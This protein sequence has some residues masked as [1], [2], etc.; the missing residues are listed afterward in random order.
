MISRR[1]SSR[2]GSLVVSSL[3]VTTLCGLFLCPR[4]GAEERKFVVMLAVPPAKSIEGGLSSLQLPSRNAIWDQYFDVL[5][6]QGPNRVDSF[7]EYW[8][9]ISYGAVSV[10][11][12][13][14]DWVEVPWPILPLLPDPNNPGER[15]P[16]VPE[17][18]TSLNGFNLPF[19]DLNGT[20]DLEQF[21]GEAF[22]QSEQ[23]FY[24]DYNGGLPGTG[25]EAFPES[26]ITQRPQGFVDFNAITGEP[27]WTPGERF[28]DLN[29]NGM[30]DAL[31]EG[32][33]DGWGSEYPSECCTPAGGSG[34]AGQSGSNGEVACEELVCAA[35]PG[36]C[37]DDPGWDE[38]CAAK[39]KELCV[40]GDAYQFPDLC[41]CEQD[42]EIDTGEFC[43]VD[44]D[45][46]WD[47]PE[48]FEDYLVIYNPDSQLAEGRWIK[49]DP[50]YKNR[51]PQSRAWAEAYIR[52]NYPGYA[53]EPLRTKDDSN[54]HGFM[55][56]FGNDKYDGPDYWYDSGSQEAPNPGSKLQQQPSP[57][58][59][60]HA[61]RTPIPDDGVNGYGLFS[62]SFEEWWEDYWHDKHLR[63]GYAEADIPQ[64]PRPPDWDLSGQKGRTSP[65]PNLQPFNPA[66]PSVGSLTP[67][68]EDLRSFNPNTGGSNARVFCIPPTDPV[69]GCDD[70][71]MEPDSTGNGSGLGTTDG[72]VYPDMW[73][74]N[75]DR[76]P[77]YYDGPA[78]FDDLPSSMYHARSVS[79][80]AWDPISG[81]WG[82]GG[83]GR[84]G[85]VTSANNWASY[86]DDRGN[87]NPESAGNADGKIPA[88]GPGAYGVHGSGGCDGGNVLNL[89]F[90]TWDHARPKPPW[91]PGGTS[92]SPAVG[93]AYYGSI[94]GEPG[95]PDLDILYTV[96]TDNNRLAWINVEVGQQG[97]PT[98]IAGSGYV[99]TDTDLSAVFRRVTAI[100][101]APPLV[102][103]DLTLYAV[104][105]NAQNT[106]V[107]G[108][109]SLDTGEATLIANIGG[110]RSISDMA[111]GRI[112][113]LVSGL[114][115]EVE[116]ASMYTLVWEDNRSKLYR[117]DLNN[118]AMVFRK[119][120]GQIGSGCQGLAY[121]EPVGTI[122]PGTFYTVDLAHKQLAR[123]DWDVN[124]EDPNA[125]ERLNLPAVPAD[126]EQKIEFSLQGLSC[127]SSVPL[128]EVPAVLFAVDSTDHVIKIDTADIEGDPEDPLSV[129]L[130]AGEADVLGILGLAAFKTRVMKRDFNLDGLIDMGEVRAEGTENYAIDHTGFTP[131]DGGPHVLYPFNRRR[132]TEDVVAA[133]DFSTDWDL[134]V[135]RVGDGSSAVN[136]LHSVVMFPPGVIADG[137][138]AGGR[139]LFH[140]PA[141]GMDLPVQVLEEPGNP[142]SPIMFSDFASP[143][144][145]TS[146]TG[147][148]IEDGSFGKGLMCHEW[149]HVW[150]GYPD[151]YD[152]DEYGGGVI[153]KPV[154]AWDIMSGGMVHPCPV[155]KEGFRGNFL[156]KDWLGT[157][158][159][160]WIDVTS[161]A[162]VLEPLEETSITL[163]DYA[164]DPSTAAFYYENP[165]NSGERFYFYRLT[166]QTPADP[167]AV[168]FS[169]NAPGE[170]V[171][172]MHTDFG[173]N[174]ESVPIQQRRG[175]HFS[176]Q[177]VQADGLHQLENGVN[178]GD[179]GDPFP[180]SED[181]TEWNAN[182]DPSSRWWGNI[183]SGLWITDV[184]EFTDYSVVTFYWRP[185]I[186]PEFR[187][188]NPPSG[189][190]VSGRYRIR[191]EAFDVYGGTKIRHFYDLDNVGYDGVEITPVA[192]QTNPQPKAP[193]TV[194]GN[195]L[196]PLN[197]LPGDGRY[198]F[199]TQM[200]LGPGADGN[201]DQAYSTPRAGLTNKG[202]GT[203]LVLNVNTSLSRIENLSIVC[204]DHSTPGAEVWTV[205]GTVSGLQSNYATTG[206]PFQTDS[207]GAI[208]SIAWQGTSGT[209]ATVSNTGGVY[210]LI[211]NAANF[212]ATDFKPGDQVR[213]LQGAPAPGFYTVTS[214]LDSRTLRLATNPGSGAGVS[215]RVHSFK[216]GDGFDFLTTGLSAYSSPITFL[217]GQIVR[218]T[219]PVI[220]VSYPD[221]ATN[222]NREVP[223]RVE[224]DGSESLDEFGNANPNLT[225]LWD[226]GDGNTSTQQTVIHTYQPGTPE[227][228]TVTL[229]VTNT[230]TQVDGE[231]SVEI[232]VNPRDGD[233]DGHPD[234]ADNCPNISNPDQFDGDGD[235]VGN[236]CDNCPTVGNPTQTDTDGDGE[237]DACETDADGDDVLNDEDNC[238]TVYNPNQADGDGDDVGDVCDNCPDDANTNQNDMD[239]DGFGDVCDNCPQ[240]YNPGQDDPNDDCNA[241]GVPD[242]CDIGFGTSEDCNE[243]GVPDECQDPD[244]VVNV[245]PDRDVAPGRTH[246]PLAPSFSVTGGVL[247]YTYQWR[248]VSG[249]STSGLTGANTASPSF[250]PPM[251]G[252][253]I[254]R[255]TVTDSSGG[256]CRYTDEMTVKVAP[257]ALNVVTEML[258]C[259]GS[260]TLPLG[261]NPTAEGG[262]PPYIYTW[263]VDSG[264]SSFAPA[265]R[266]TANPTLTP[267]SVEDYSISLS[268]S[269][270]SSP[271]YTATATV[272]IGVGDGPTISAGLA[273]TYHPI[274][275]IGDALAL[276]GA[277]TASG[278][279]PPYFY[280]WTIEMTV[281]ANLESAAVIS[282]PNSANP[283]F[284]ANTKGAYVIHMAVTDT[285]GCTAET[286]FTVTVVNDPPYSTFPG[287]DINP[288][289]CGTCGA[290][291]AASMG[292]ML[293]A[294]LMVLS[295][296]RLARRRNKR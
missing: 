238:P 108:T 294:Y 139:G 65:I 133:A 276:G 126:P 171:L 155:L 163:T 146:E 89:E 293:G 22:N 281:P 181:V 84:L 117:L 237:G 212:Q 172:V 200:E 14:T 52:A 124:P 241:N 42:G 137:L 19:T 148:P 272:H 63:A 187:Y 198:Y 4:A 257:L 85:E 134:W 54:A 21:Q 196:V 229:T 101:F 51:D 64:A 7:A 131:N 282:N 132:L 30:Y 262:T 270:S 102:D 292:S 143:M 127:R 86:G 6:N 202:H 118:G 277:P 177:I 68:S 170:G 232:V 125:P 254:V 234:D 280:D 28:R 142:L 236:V 213:I 37:S 176:Y 258:G 16:L 61:P 83:D 150:E 279:Y 70:P 166:Y 91:L 36:C 46:Q 183:Y 217:N 39:A 191:Y 228:V 288:G 76:F 128:Q 23:L 45:N 77:D 152:Y 179:P 56:R 189:T 185:K 221:D 78:E 244:V 195:F 266:R 295:G 94:E 161:L 261:G 33:W 247:P 57:G 129:E 199:Y 3:V 188:I 40:E 109:I 209:G 153:N 104:G 103:G 207:G 158:H 210:K 100:A 17:G 231:D 211:D 74:S 53:G 218:T 197:T 274:I 66:S 167:D 242:A 13:V 115:Q 273:E 50:S 140:L 73:D 286:Q 239:G 290:T 107:L 112:L 58:M 269:D 175:D 268:V 222:P 49:L 114:P 24:I 203:I 79:G 149:L 267:P 275:T 243:D 230:A 105:V 113:T 80:V 60:V 255:C 48:P 12:E 136:Y 5:K 59:W 2:S 289:A 27:V 159:E 32:S 95:E 233:S 88:G 18:A 264:P 9:E 193:G 162:D 31:L 251:N 111:Y 93:C 252:T 135:M 44:L 225:Y 192:P 34:C 168:N 250:T 182:T 123:F 47:F 97:Y 20:G 98:G 165:N 62:W 271:A 214:V 147:E 82:Y 122:D 145:G 201:Y 120:M 265:D 116:P 43:D 216:T 174:P 206:A 219:T 215:Y 249:P 67:P 223:L 296:R 248:I 226:L 205:D 227:R 130:T 285:A 245:G 81:A 220:A 235:G 263:T 1:E 278:G 253:Y 92:S 69:N 55:A 208:F 184:E 240:F 164:F 90:L 154:G 259:V 190:L 178:S 11:G 169:R 156:G 38:T 71:P 256:T 96:D 144:G 291:G 283:T 141:P 72:A 138:S 15:I 224:F 260:A 160:P 186:V 194:T 246:A 173:D 284:T 121:D 119:R 106:N 8:Y 151:L 29:N 287:T 26:S 99:G 75:L 180:G 10:A 204:V 25:T 35:L 41:T 157:D 87:G 110:N